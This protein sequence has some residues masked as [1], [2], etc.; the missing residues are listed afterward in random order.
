MKILKDIT[1]AGKSAIAVKTFE[2]EP[3]VK[4][5]E[6]QI[7]LSVLAGEGLVTVID[8]YAIHSI[9]VKDT[10]DK[11]FEYFK[12]KSLIELS[13]FRDM[14]GLSRNVAVTL[15]E[16]FDSKGITCREGNSRRLVKKLMLV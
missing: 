3:G 9:V 2:A 1:M 10:L 6:L 4:E 13:C 12:R 16:Y 11:L 15:L 14:T 5:P 7:V 8:K